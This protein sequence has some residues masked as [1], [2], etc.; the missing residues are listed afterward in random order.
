[1]WKYFSEDE[2][3]CKHT[4]ICK[5]DPEFMETLEKIREEAIRNQAN[6]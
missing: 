3:K 1:M 6:K 4:G 2:L 5:M